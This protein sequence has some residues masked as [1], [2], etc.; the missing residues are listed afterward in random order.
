MNDYES[1]INQN[2]L[3]IMNSEPLHFCLEYREVEIAGQIVELT[4]KEFD[5]LALLI[6]NP[7]RVFTYE[8]IMDIIWKEDYSY[9]SK[10]A[11]HNHISNL[12]RK[13]RE[14]YP[15]H[16]FILSVHGVGYKF[17]PVP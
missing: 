11:I 7:R 5:I 16:N 14:L 8:M 17:N 12:K 9:Y 2:P 13:L 6:L 15:K 10:K 3:T 1:W 4:A